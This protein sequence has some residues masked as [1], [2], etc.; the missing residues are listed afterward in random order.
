MR[1]IMTMITFKIFIWF[2]Q[3]GTNVCCVNKGLQSLYGDWIELHWIEGILRCSPFLTIRNM[4]LKV[5]WNI[6][7]PVNFV[8]VYCTFSNCTGQVLYTAD[9][10]EIPQSLTWGIFIQDTAY[11]IVIQWSMTLCFI[12]S[13][14]NML[15][16]VWKCLTYGIAQSLHMHPFDMTIHMCIY[17]E[18]GFNWKNDMHVGIGWLLGSQVS[19]IIIF[20]KVHGL[21][22]KM[23]FYSLFEG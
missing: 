15:Y 9:I 12:E 18:T 3:K 4:R 13:Q 22:F 21:I 23:K 7:I 8:P 1:L 14:R 2:Y 11:L 20:L 17:S 5:K 16:P 19:S 6:T 10:K